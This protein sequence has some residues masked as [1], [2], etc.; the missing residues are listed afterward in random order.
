MW[1]PHCLPTLPLPEL[2]RCPSLDICAAKGREGFNAAAK[3]SAA[4]LENAHKI[5]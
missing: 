5:R 3:S 2:V 1:L 4:S